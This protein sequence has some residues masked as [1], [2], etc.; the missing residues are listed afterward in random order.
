MGCLQSHTS[1]KCVDRLYTL[2]GVYFARVGNIRA[3]KWNMVLLYVLALIL[4]GLFT[5]LPNRVMGQM[6]F[7]G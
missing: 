6:L 2:R 3:H 5:L 1:L 4:T 7:G